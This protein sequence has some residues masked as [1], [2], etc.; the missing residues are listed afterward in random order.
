MTGKYTPGPWAAHKWD[1]E[2]WKEKRWHVST[3]DGL[4]VCVSPRY[5][6]HANLSDARLIAAAP[7]LLDALKRVSDYI[8]YEGSNVPEYVMDAIAKAEGRE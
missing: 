4:A 2:E 3:D 1:G 7:D 5:A 6:D 8:C